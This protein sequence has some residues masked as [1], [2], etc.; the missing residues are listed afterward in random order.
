MK[1]HLINTHLLVP[2]SRSSARSRSNIGVM[3]LKRWVFRRALVFHKH[4]L[5][6]N[7]FKWVSS[8]FRRGG[9][10]AQLSPFPQKI[11][12]PYQKQI[13]V[14][15][16]VFFLDRKYSVDLFLI[17]GFSYFHLLFYTLFL[18]KL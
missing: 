15:D 8:G 12:C 7:V 4:I 18:I 16:L 6:H 10:V 13:S 2:R 14:S 17:Q 1:A 11:F 9:G 5:F 3:F